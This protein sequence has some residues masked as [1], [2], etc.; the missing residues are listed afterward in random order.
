MSTEDE[1]SRIAGL[2]NTAQ[3]AKALWALRDAL[4]RTPRSP[5]LLDLAA[6]LARAAQSRAMD[7]AY[8]KATD[9]SRKAQELESIAREAK[10]YL[11]P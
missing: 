3:F 2:I 4:A 5:S 11:T 10:E 9:G 7:L 6:T 1:A 8:N